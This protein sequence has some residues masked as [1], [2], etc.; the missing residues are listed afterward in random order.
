MGVLEGKLAASS[1][2]LRNVAD[3]CINCKLCWIECPSGVDIPGMCLEVKAFDVAQRGLSKRDARLVNVR[4]NSAKAARWAPWS[5][6]ALKI[7]GPFMG[8]KRAP[9]F[10]KADVTPTRK[11]ERKVLYFAG[12]FAD[13]NDPHGEKQATIDVL[14]RNGHRI[15]PPFERESDNLLSRAR[16]RR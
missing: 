16:W 10:I 2:E 7:A 15:Y 1:E 6:L 9:E 4:E 13:Y 5:N 14:E 8:M 3:L 11:S 12:C